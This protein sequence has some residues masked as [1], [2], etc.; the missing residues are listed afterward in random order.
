MSRS[1]NRCE[2]GPSSWRSRFPFRTLCGRCAIRRNA[3]PRPPQWRARI[4]R[5]PTLGARDGDLHRSHLRHRA[6]SAHQEDG[7]GVDHRR[8]EEIPIE[9][10]QLRIPGEVRNPL[11]VVLV[12]LVVVLVLVATPLDHRVNRIDRLGDGI[13][14]VQSTLFVEVL[15]RTL[16]VFV[17]L[18]VA[19]RLV[20]LDVPADVDDHIFPAVLLE[21]LGHVVGVR[22]RLLFCDRGGEAAQLFQPMSGVPAQDQ[23][24]GWA[25]APAATPRQ[26]ERAAEKRNAVNRG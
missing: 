13:V 9:P 17:G 6:R 11:R 22:P 26:H 1:S 23:N 3:P 12:V 5:F 21:M 20:V 8:H 10:A 2:I 18:V 15:D 25:C 7:H 4:P 16:E 14:F 24:S 19:A